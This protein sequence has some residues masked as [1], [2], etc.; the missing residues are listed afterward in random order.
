ML[1]GKGRASSSKEGKQQAD[2]SGHNDNLGE[3]VAP[4]N[5]QDIL[6]V[7]VIERQDEVSTIFSL[8]TD[9]ARRETG[10]NKKRGAGA[11][12]TGGRLGDIF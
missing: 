2:H 1:R 9:A 4:K 8:F 3:G 11:G 5:R 12:S 6:S 7:A 10:W